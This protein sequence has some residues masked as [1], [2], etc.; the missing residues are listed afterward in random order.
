MKNIDEFINESKDQSAIGKKIAKLLDGDIINAIMKRMTNWDE[1]KFE[2][3]REPMF[4]IADKDININSKEHVR[5]MEWIRAKTAKHYPQ[6]TG[7]INNYDLLNDDGDKN[8]SVLG[9][10]MDRSF[11][12][13]SSID[14][15]K[16]IIDLLNEE[17]S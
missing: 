14:T 10:F 15:F 13:I 17:T 4:L 1:N 2:W 5:N 16:N 3:S 7:T 12:P 8:R 11:F 6:I 9:I